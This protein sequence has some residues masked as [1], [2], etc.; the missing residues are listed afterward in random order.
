MTSL[1]LKDSPATTVLTFGFEFPSPNYKLKFHHAIVHEVGQRFP[2]SRYS[3]HSAVLI[4]RFMTSTQDK[5]PLKYGNGM[6][7][8]W[9]GGPT[10]GGP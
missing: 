3:M 4:G 1:K 9:E 10:L 8:F 5:N 7:S 6:R 2:A